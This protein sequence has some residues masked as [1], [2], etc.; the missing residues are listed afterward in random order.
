MCS[1]FVAGWAIANRAGNATQ[2][3]QVADSVLIA[4]PDF[5]GA[6]AG[7]MPDVRGLGREE[8]TQALV[9]AGIPAS[10]ISTEERPAAGPS[11]IVVQQSPVFGHANPT[12]VLL[13]VSIPAVVP[14][15]TGLTLREAIDALN[16]MGAR[17]LQEKV[18]DPAATV[19]NV[20]AS[21]PAAGSPLPETITLSVA[22]KAGERLLGER[23]AIDGYVSHESDGVFGGKQ[24]ASIM[25]MSASSSA[26]SAAWALN[27]GAAR[28]TT[29][30]ALED[31]E[32][33]DQAVVRV[34][35][36]GVPLGSVTV[37]SATPV[38]LDVPLSGVGTLTIEVQRIGT[39][40]SSWSSVEVVLLDAKLL[41]SYDQLQR[42]P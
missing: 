15:L 40:D 8:A 16:G 11:G 27:T 42:L 3:H 37:G 23:S 35:G 39:D 9:D 41:G 12:S 17:V 7:L 26:E 20:V 30:V 29:Q 18:Y 14:D 31:P 10:V 24:Y 33:G 13:I 34:F 22:D 1:A 19:G 36:D 6:S 32:P 21:S 2:Q 25:S 4:V 38:S 28:L 5:G